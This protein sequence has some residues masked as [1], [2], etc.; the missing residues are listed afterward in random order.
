MLGVRTQTQAEE[1]RYCVGQVDR[2]I[3][4]ANNILRQQRELLADVRRIVGEEYRSGD[5]SSELS[6]VNQF[7]DEAGDNGD[8]D[9]TAVNGRTAA[10]G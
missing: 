3:H 5:D 8:G 6:N 10:S 1:M 7:G 9:G 4:L 2:V